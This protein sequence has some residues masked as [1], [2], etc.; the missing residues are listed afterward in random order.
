MSF[1]LHLSLHTHRH[2][3]DFTKN[4]LAILEIGNDLVSINPLTKFQ[5]RRSHIFL[6]IAYMSFSPKVWQPPLGMV[7]KFSTAIYYTYFHSA[8]VIKWTQD[9]VEETR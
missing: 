3:E 7:T 4:M 6:V 1:S 8:R 9:K 2:A 5:H